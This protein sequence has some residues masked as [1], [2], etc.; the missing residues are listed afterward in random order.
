MIVGEIL[1][2]LLCILTITLPAGLGALGRLLPAALGLSHSALP[3]AL[4]LR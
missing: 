2:I 1:T 4:I 3:I